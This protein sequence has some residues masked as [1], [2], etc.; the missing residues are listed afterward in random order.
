MV[1]GRNTLVKIRSNQNASDDSL[2]LSI[3]VCTVHSKVNV[4]G[5]PAHK[6]FQDRA[7]ARALAAHHS[8][9]WQVE[10]A[11]LSRAA[12]G[13]LEA[14]DQRD[15]LLHPA[16]AHRNGAARSPVQLLQILFYSN[17]RVDSTRESTE[18]HHR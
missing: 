16:V 10:A 6:V 8:D 11:A 3:T 9:L 2:I 14:V 13:V 18:N 7:L 17:S 4:R 12:Q 1:T 5:L 15:K